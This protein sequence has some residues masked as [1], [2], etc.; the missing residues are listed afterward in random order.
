[1]KTYILFFISLSCL[2]AGIGWYIWYLRKQ[3]KQYPGLDEDPDSIIGTNP[4]PSMLGRFGLQA[5][6]AASN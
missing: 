2:I 3:M 1:M 5:Q 6:N 4:Q